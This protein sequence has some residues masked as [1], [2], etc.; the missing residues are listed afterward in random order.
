MTQKLTRKQKIFVNKYVE[1]GNGTQAALEAYDI[2]PNGSDPEK[3]A[4]VIAVE[5][6]GKPSVRNALLE[7]LPDE[8][9]SK[10]HFEGLNA[11]RGEEPDFAVRHKYLDTAYKIKGS[12]AP[13]KHVSINVDVEPNQRIIDLANKLNA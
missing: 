4:S 2:D 5:N 7:A 13:E 3:T 12:Y 6:L 8:L 1:T 11:T 10:V 9:L